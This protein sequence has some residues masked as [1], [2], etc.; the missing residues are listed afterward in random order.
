MA[1]VIQGIRQV[2]CSA[3]LLWC[4]LWGHV[5]SWAQLARSHTLVEVDDTQPL[6]LKNC[7]STRSWSELVLLDFPTDITESHTSKPTLLPRIQVDGS[8]AAGG[9]PGPL[10][11]VLMA[12]ILSGE[13]N[14]S[15]DDCMTSS[16]VD[17]TRIRRSHSVCSSAAVALTRTL[18]ASEVFLPPLRSSAAA[19]DVSVAH[20]STLT[21]GEVGVRCTACSLF[22]VCRCE[23][24]WRALQMKTRLVCTPGICVCFGD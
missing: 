12:S 16:S 18:H 3:S 7:G 10:T 20:R 22:C 21:Q 6:S 24:R 1:R 4:S 17:L 5:L 8:A 15:P 13:Q 19:S 23:V 11:D 9:Q 14:R 2:Q